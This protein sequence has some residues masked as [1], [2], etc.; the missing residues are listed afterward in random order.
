MNK[1]DGVKSRRYGDWGEAKAAEQLRCEGLEIVECNSRPAVYD[2]RLE[3]DIVAYDPAMDTMVF[4]EVKQHGTHME[5]E[6]VLRG[7]TERK[8]RNL[9]QAF[10]AWRSVNKW[11]GLCRFDVVEVYGRPGCSKPEIEHVK[12]VS[13]LPRRQREEQ[14]CC[15]I[16][17]IL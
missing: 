4:V 9:R 2:R 14:G 1:E 16:M 17:N 12:G 3:I 8:R 6:G 7:I 5:G 13:L 11:Y 10:G 15:S